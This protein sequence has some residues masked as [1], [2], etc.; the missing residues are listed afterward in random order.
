MALDWL[1][2]KD[3]G[4]V[5]DGVADDTKALQEALDAAAEGCGTVF[6]P[7]GTYRTGMLTLPMETCLRAEPT[8]GYQ[9]EGRTVLI[10]ARE[11]Q[12]CVLEVSDA[13]N[14]TVYGVCIDG[15]HM[16]ECLHG[17]SMCRERHEHVKFEH[18]LRLEHLRVSNCT[19]NGINL[20]GAWAV[21]IRQSQCF[22]NEL[23]GVY[24]DGTDAFVTDNWFSCNGRSGFGG[25]TWNSAVN[26][27]A[28]RV[29]WNKGP[30]MRLAGGMRYNIT[31]NYF[32]RSG[33]PAILI[34]AAENYHKRLHKTHTVIPYAITVT[35]NN[36][37]RSGAQAEP[38]S[39]ED[40]HVLL[41]RAAGCV[42]SANTCNIWKNDGL[43]G[44]FSPATAIV[45]DRCAHCAITSNVMLPGAVSE[46]IRDLGGHGEGMVIEHNTGA[47]IPEAALGC[48]DP[49]TP[50]HFMSEGGAPWYS[51]Q[52]SGESN[53]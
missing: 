17:I 42:I 49:F 36:L 19:G 35:G 32:D 2:P 14:S 43:H 34:D 33:G 1:D 20:V 52:L 25:S 15:R 24:L 21:S 7:R 23:D 38:G 9:R 5:G 27:S 51:E 28:N 30:G 50:V 45:V 18:S 29:E 53:G 13:I 40:C 26:F 6:L 41:R 16:G 47:V 10:P 4:A 37:V 44:R 22:G 12:E 39:D 3:F 48:R 31:G 11:D 8:W 46:L